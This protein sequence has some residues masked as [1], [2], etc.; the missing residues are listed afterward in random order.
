MPSKAS[1]SFYENYIRE[2]VKTLN[3]AQ[4]S[5][6][7]VPEDIRKKTFELEKAM[8]LAEEKKDAIRYMAIVNKWRDLFL[9]CKPEKPTNNTKE[10]EKEPWQEQQQKSFKQTTMF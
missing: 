5:M 8:M 6:L 4:V 7:S 2:A 1:N 9:T 3:H 10:K